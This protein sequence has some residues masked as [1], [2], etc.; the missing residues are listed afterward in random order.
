MRDN[1]L[2]REPPLT[3]VLIVAGLTSAGHLWAQNVPTFR[4]ST[5]LM[6]VDVEVAGS[7]GS[8]LTGLTQED[9]RVTDEGQEQTVVAFSAGEVPLDIILLFDISSS[10][11]TQV[12]K[13]A[14]VAHEGLE[15]VTARGP[16]FGYGVQRRR[17][18][19]FSFFGE[20]RRG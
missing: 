1:R 8:P 10:M 3:L 14:A 11:R 7:N 15:R 17:V 9:F 2:F 4:T 5:N 18:C 16:S 13:V 19:H 6:H 12:K 20:L